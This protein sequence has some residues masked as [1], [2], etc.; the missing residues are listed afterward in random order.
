MGFSYFKLLLKIIVAWIHL[1]CQTI[2]SSIVLKAV[3]CPR[4]LQVPLSRAATEPY[5]VAFT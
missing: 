4:N 2:F 1:D 5:L 3:H